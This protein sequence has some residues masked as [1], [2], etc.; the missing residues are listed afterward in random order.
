[1]Q[2]VLNIK[3][4]YMLTPE[5]FK[6]CLLRARRRPKQQVDPVVLIEGN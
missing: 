3:N 2:E 5:A 1:M 4:L 6:T